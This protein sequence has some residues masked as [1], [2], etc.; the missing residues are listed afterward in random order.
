[1]TTTLLP[2]GRMLTPTAEITDAAILIRDGGIEELGLRE[3]MRLPAGAEEISATDK[4][5]IP[6]FVDVHIHGAGGRDVMEG[7]AEPLAGAPKTVDRHRTTSVVA[8]T[9][10][11]RA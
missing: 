1:M 11:A 8:T 2:S 4:T 6:G 3:G 5:A 7:S 9:V 10:T